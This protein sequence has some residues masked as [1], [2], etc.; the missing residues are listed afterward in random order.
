MGKRY[1]QTKRNDK[2]KRGKKSEKNKKNR[3]LNRE[4]K[5]MKEFSKENRRKFKKNKDEGKVLQ[6]NAIDNATEEKHYKSKDN[7]TRSKNEKEFK[8]SNENTESKIKLNENI[9]NGEE[10]NEVDEN[11]FS[12]NKFDKYKKNDAIEE[13]YLR[14]KLICKDK[15]R[16]LNALLKTSNI[17]LEELVELLEEL[18]ERI[19]DNK[20][21]EKITLREK[22]CLIEETLKIFEIKKSKKYILLRIKILELLIKVKEQLF[23]P[24]SHEITKIF[25]EIFNHVPS[26]SGGVLTGYKLN[27]DK[28]NEEVSHILIKKILRITYKYFNKFSNNIG[29]IDLIP[30]ITNKLSAFDHEDLKDLILVLNKH[31]EYL[32]NDKENKSLMRIEELRNIEV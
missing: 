6:K 26:E 28:W 4:D 2:T 17:N 1:F 24:L 30:F 19:Y 10:N 18:F 15:L 16:E 20:N 12:K 25:E 27:D 11:N 29:F 13:M 9:L 5:G 3:M 31:K 32:E 23:V 21:N 8:R 7:L 14:G 22:V